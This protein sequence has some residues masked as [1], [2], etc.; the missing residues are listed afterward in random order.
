MVWAACKNCGKL[1]E[2]HSKEFC[3]TC[4]KKLLWKPKKKI[5]KRCN[6]ELPM[7]A[8]GLCAGC[9][10]FVFH[11]DKTKM[12][13]QTKRH[14]IA[15]EVYRKITKNCAICGFGKMVDLHHLDENKKNIFESNLVGLCP[16]HHRM[17]HDFRYK[18]EISNLLKQ[19]GFKIPENKK[20][21]FSLKD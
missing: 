14:G 4:Y 20:M 15:I 5:C 2:R 17:F 1:A 16:N 19:K 9:Y 12:R 7:H 21:S 6:R 13:N 10:N 18:E 11:L 8:K 3:V